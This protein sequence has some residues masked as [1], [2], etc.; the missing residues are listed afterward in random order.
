MANNISVELGELTDRL[1]SLSLTIENLSE[2]VD[3]FNID[4]D[5]LCDI[6]HKLEDAAK[7]K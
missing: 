7:V 2:M 6:A 3:C 1:Y 5:A 4:L